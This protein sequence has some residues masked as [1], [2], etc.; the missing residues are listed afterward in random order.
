MNK[1]QLKQAYKETPKMM[2]IYRIFNQKENRV[3]LGASHDIQARLNRHQAELNF[4][5]HRLKAL[6][7]DW[8]R[9]GSNAFQFEIVEE[10]SPPEDNLDYD[11]KEDLAALLEMLLEKENYLPEQLYI[12]TII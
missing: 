4:G 1:K 8:K 5:V 12:G 3:F 9:L 10:L 11:P 6:Q 2:G 7:S